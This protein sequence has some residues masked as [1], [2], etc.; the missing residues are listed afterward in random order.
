MN[1]RT[2]GAALAAT[3]ILGCG[4]DDP[5]GGAS[6]DQ[7]GSSSDGTSLDGGG[8]DGA[9]GDTN[10]GGDASDAAQADI[11]HGTATFTARAGVL[12]VFV[13]HA[14]EDSELALKDANEATVATGKADHL[15]SLVF[16]NVPAG[17]G[18][19]V[20]SVGATPAAFS[21]P[22]HVWGVQESKPTQAFY[23]AQ[24][25]K[26]GNGYITTRD[27]TTL[28]YFATL[29]G[30]ADKGP[31]PTIVNYSGYDPGRPGSKV[32]SKEQ[33]FYCDAIPVL[34]N[35]PSDASAMIA[36]ISGYAT[37]SVNMRGTGCSGGAYDYFETMQ[38]LD[39]YD[40][41][42]TVAAQPWVKGH[43]VGMTGLSYPGITQLFVARAQPP[44]LAAITPLSVIGNTVTTLVP[45]GILNSGFALNWINNV[46]KRAAPYGQGWEQARVDGGDTICKENQLLHDQRVNN[47]E[48]A[49]DSKYYDPAT[50]DPLNPTKWAHE[51]KVPVFLAG[52]WQDEQTGPFF[53]TLLDRFKGAQSRRFIVYN[54]VHSDGFAPQVLAEWKAFLDL[55]V[56]EQKPT[57]SPVIEALVPELTKQI[58]GASIGFPADRWAGIK[59]HAE[60]LA[61]WQAEPEVHAIFDSGA[62]QPLGAPQGAFALDFSEWP[63]KATKARRWYFGAQGALTDLPPAATTTTDGAGSTFKLDPDA[64]QR[65]IVSK[66]GVWNVMPNYAWNEPAAGNAV[67]FV[68]A[69]L[70]ADIVMLGTGSVDFW[71]RSTAKDVTDAD[72]EVN[73]TEVR[74]DGK[75]VYVQSGWLRAQFRALTQESTELWPEPS[76]LQ[77]D[78]APLVPHTW[79]KVRV[80]IAGFGHA[81]RKG[82]RVRITIDTPGDSRADWRFDLQTYAHPVTYDVA[83]S[84]AYPSSVLLP[85]IEG[86]VVPSAAV[87]P[88]CPSLRGQPCR[89]YTPHANVAAAP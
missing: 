33:E 67:A 80:A 21:G 37:V 19:R 58:F 60:A 42:E 49:K 57:M 26:V 28:A 23:Q 84:A 74:P 1:G 40:I 25:I 85:A 31:Y 88:P 15:G 62:V 61:K 82:S 56:A 10:V 51:I 45:G 35:A 11:D 6:G 78:V 71:L 8:S 87:L 41:I 9:T 13:T 52:A 83:H 27:G 7:D 47:V 70:A 34:C 4:S 53:V 69:P 64:G 86:A 63:A 43:K 36:A 32:V 3:L 48:Q 20:H 5:A 16:R 76:L 55:Y 44:S 65:G 68:S 46:Y 12:Q 72:L 24:S 18:Y 54:G 59:T 89:A 50:I 14:K 30:P 22:L 29:P 75:E 77:S 2:I 38:L 39:G 79:Q 81:F 17:D 66:G 73:L